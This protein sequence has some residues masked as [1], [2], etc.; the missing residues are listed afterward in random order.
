[1]PAGNAAS[2]L[3][4]IAA[5]AHEINVDLIRS[6]ADYLK[7]AAPNAVIRSG[8]YPVGRG[9]IEVTVILSRLTDIARVRYYYS[10]SMAPSVER[11]E[12]IGDSAGQG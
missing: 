10:R 8:D 2:A 7:K 3:Y 12:A 6:L 4:L 5:P 1:V 9:I 11:P